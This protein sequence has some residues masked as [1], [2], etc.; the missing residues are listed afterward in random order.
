MICVIALWCATPLK[1]LMWLAD[2]W[3]F[4]KCNV[5]STIPYIPEDVRNCEWPELPE[6]YE[7]Q[8]SGFLQDLL[9]DLFCLKMWVRSGSTCR[10]GRSRSFHIRSE[11]WIMVLHLSTSM[12]QWKCINRFIQWQPLW[13]CLRILLL[14]FV[15]NH[16]HLFWTSQGGF[17]G[18]QS[19]L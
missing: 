14:C 4:S 17:G 18:Q 16:I 7:E 11:E 12:G 8:K 15:R 10:S 19:F 1:S 13:W 6:N 3:Y 5:C 2:L 9:D